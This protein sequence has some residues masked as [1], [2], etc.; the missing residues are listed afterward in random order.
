M[1][2]RR[3]E[4]VFDDVFFEF[5][6]DGVPAATPP[7]LIEELL[8]VIDADDDVMEQLEPVVQ[9]GPILSITRLADGG[10]QVFIA[11]P[12]E[13]DITSDGE[14]TDP[15]SRS[16]DISTGTG[17][18]GVTFVTGSTSTDRGTLSIDAQCP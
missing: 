13:I 16:L 14:P 5:Q 7:E 15:S 10:E 12:G 17:P 6:L 11:D 9:Y 2:A 3:S 1:S 18:G 8:G 4:P